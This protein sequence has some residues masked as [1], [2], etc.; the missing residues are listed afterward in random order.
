MHA[1][2]SPIKWF[3]YYNTF[4]SEWEGE[5]DIYKDQLVVIYN[6]LWYIHDVTADS[7]IM[8]KDSSGD[9]INLFMCESA[10]LESIFCKEN[11]NNLVGYRTWKWLDF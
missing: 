5:L 9:V 7:M 11:D 10:E 6:K 1:G 4:L 2:R 3:V 8:I